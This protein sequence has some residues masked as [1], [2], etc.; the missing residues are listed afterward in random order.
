VGSTAGHLS[1]VIGYHDNG[2]FY[3]H[4]T[5]GAGTDGSYDGANQLYSW[6]YIAPVRMWAA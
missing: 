2:Q 1:V 3:V 5:Y 6:N 4:D